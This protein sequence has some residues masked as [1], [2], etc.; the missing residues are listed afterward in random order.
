MK[1][2]CLDLF[3]PGDS[4]DKQNDSGQKE[5]SNDCICNHS[6]CYEQFTLPVCCYFGLLEEECEAQIGGQLC[7]D[8]S[9]IEAVLG[10][11]HGADL[12]G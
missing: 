11:R 8:H 12:L 2:P 6:N 5:D 7:V 10:G 1:T 9:E 4:A 3:V